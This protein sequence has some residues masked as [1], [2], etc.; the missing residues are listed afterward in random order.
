MAAEGVQSAI[1]SLAGDAARAMADLTVPSTFALTTATRTALCFGLF[2]PPPSWP[3]ERLTLG[4]LAYRAAFALAFGLMLLMPLCGMLFATVIFLPVLLPVLVVVVPVVLL[5]VLIHRLG[6]KSDAPDGCARR[7]SMDAPPDW[8]TDHSAYFSTAT[9]ASRARRQRVAAELIDAVNPSSATRMNAHIASCTG[10]AVYGCGV[11]ASAHVGGLRALEKHGLQYEKLTTLA[12]VSA[13]AVVVAC[14]AVGYRA[15]EL[16]QVVL[17]LPFPRFMQPELASILRTAGSFLYGTLDKLGMDRAKTAVAPLAL[18]NGPGVNTGQLLERLT[19]DALANKCGDADITLGQVARAF[20]KRLVIIV[21]ELDSG[22]EKRL[23]PESDPDLPVRV[24]VRMSMGVPGLMEPFLYNGHVYCDGGMMND[25]PM[26]ALPES[27]RL[28]LM[29]RPVE[30]VAFNSSVLEE[31][32]GQSALDSVPGVK[33]DLAAVA[34]RLKHAGVY[35]VRNP[36]DFF[37]TCIQVM[38]DANLMLQIRASTEIHAAQSEVGRLWKAMSSTASSVK[39]GVNSLL[40]RQATQTVG[41]RLGAETTPAA[42]AHAGVPPAVAPPT[43]GQGGDAPFAAGLSKLAPQI[44]T[45]CAG[46]LDAFDFGLTADMHKDL[47]RVGQLCV[48]MHAAQLE[49]EARGPQV[50]TFLARLQ[51]ILL[52]LHL[53]AHRDDKLPSPPKAPQ[54]IGTD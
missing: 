13:G 20:G 29:V 30:W 23:T 36:I 8:Q 45:L 28:G 41:E 4:R 40:S 17:S 39:S 11:L 53:K 49:G 19:G 25:F 3:P 21:T 42:D 52:M 10:L 47:Y 46:E 1:G 24:A 50:M 15:E 22:R 7:G 6:S 54:R 48:H 51:V 32:V 16:H 18:G 38:M 33:Q 2:L 14:V 31:I 35:S 12:G 5:P 44:M 37:M 34:Q 26:D 43:T 27:G 9:A